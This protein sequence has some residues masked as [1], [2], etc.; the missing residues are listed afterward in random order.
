MSMDMFDS[1]DRQLADVCSPAAIRQIETSRD[2]TALWQALADSG[3]ADLLAPEQTAYSDGA[4]GG[5]G[6]GW[7][8]AWQVLFA[9]GRHAVCVPFG[10]TLYA[11]AVLAHLGCA[12]NPK[13]SIAI[14]GFGRIT[15]QGNLTAHGVSAVGLADFVLIQAGQTVYHVAIA[16]CALEFLGGPGCFDANVV[17]SNPRPIG[18]LSLGALAQGLALVLAVQLAGVADRV[19]EMTL[20]YANDRSQF[21]K[22]IGRFQAIQQ[23]M[24]EMAEQVYALRVASQLGCQTTAWQPHPLATALAKSHTSACA[25]RIA[26]IAHAVHGAI[27]VT[28]EYDLQI[29]TRKLYE[30]A[31]SGGGAQYWAAQLGTAA[32]ESDASLLDFMRED[33]FKSKRLGLPAV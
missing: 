10:Q 5:A 8:D 17:V 21:G 30:W 23:Q 27:G 2:G 7:D 25:Q 18:S 13:H 14:S 29:Y 28:R 16:D 3:F 24:T 19:L 32:L 11:R 1:I 26:S 33:V 20:D 6:L 31:R 9:A 4:S 15:E 22:P 12:V